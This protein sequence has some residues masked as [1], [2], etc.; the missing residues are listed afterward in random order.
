MTN[1]IDGTVPHL[2]AQHR[3]QLCYTSPLNDEIMMQ[4]D[5]KGG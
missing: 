2:E 5:Q 3:L 4:C 1:T